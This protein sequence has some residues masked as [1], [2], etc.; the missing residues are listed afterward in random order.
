MGRTDDSY[1]LTVKDIQ[2]GT[3][4][5]RLEHGSSSAERQIEVT[6]DNLTY[7]IEINTATSRPQYVVFEVVPRNAVVVIDKKRAQIQPNSAGYDFCN[8]IK[9]SAIRC[10]SF[11]AANQIPN[12]E[13]ML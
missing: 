2:F 3:H 4:L 5:L 8:P 12:E 13:S 11:L 1:T 6:G 10:N 9:S 7:R